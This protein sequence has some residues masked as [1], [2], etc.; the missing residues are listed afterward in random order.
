M[1][2]FGRH[3]R[4]YRLAYPLALGAACLALAGCAAGNVAS[5]SGNAHDVASSDH[6]SAATAPRRHAAHARDAAAY[7]AVGL[8]SWYGADF[9]GRRTADGSTFDMHSL[10]AAHRTLPLHCTVR[11]T[12]LANHRSVLVRVNDRGPFVGNRIIDLSAQSAKVL[13]FYDRGL[14]KVKVD[15]VGPAS[16]PSASP[17]PPAPRVTAAAT[18]P[19]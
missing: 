13:G 5:R 1:L 11:V 10:T 14:A 7:S 15:Y 16:R 6:H 19:L 3:H 12:N 9:H 2:A 17:A 18:P 4:S 8:A